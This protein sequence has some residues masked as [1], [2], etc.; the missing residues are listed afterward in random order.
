[1]NLTVAQ[2]QSLGIKKDCD[3]HAQDAESVAQEAL[4]MYG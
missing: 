3:L 1:M 4:A 2:M